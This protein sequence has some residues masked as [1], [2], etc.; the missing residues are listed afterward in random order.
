LTS[1]ART[2]RAKLDDA[3]LSTAILIAADLSG[4]NLISG[5]LVGTLVDRAD[6]SSAVLFGADLTRARWPRDAPVPGRLRRA[7]LAR[8]DST[9]AGPAA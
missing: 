9:T 6:L 3:D 1:P 7:G 5:L 4:A 2:S 8:S